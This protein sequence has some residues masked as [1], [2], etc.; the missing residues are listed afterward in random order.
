[1]VFWAEL[2]LCSDP[3]WTRVVGP[4]PPTTRSR[5]PLTTI[6]QTSMSPKYPHYLLLS[7][8]SQDESSASQW[9]FVLQNVTTKQR[10]SAA[11]SEPGDVG[12]ERLELL[13]VV[14]GLEA[15]E[16]P[17]RVTLV[18]RSRY[19]SRGIRRGV[20]E[21]R[22][23]DWKWER[24][25][26]IVPVRD[27]DLWQ[28]V[29]RALRFHEVDCQSWLFE[30]AECT[31]TATE[32]C[33]E[34]NLATVGGTRPMR[35]GPPTKVRKRRRSRKWADRWTEALDVISKP[36]GLTLGSGSTA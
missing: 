21:W 14:R 11:D 8:A 22:E 25:G 35:Q 17:S 12:R 16:C 33:Q 31:K 3:Q 9:R 4:S 28:R 23:N 30:S 19:V 34:S 20:R 32:S 6:R 1:M 5:S 2:V 24:F 10:F 15:L 13:A 29:E 26:R 27:H 36:V 7:E 18:T